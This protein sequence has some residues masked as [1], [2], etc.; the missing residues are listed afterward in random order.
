[1]K[2][3][4]VWFVSLH[5]TSKAKSPR[6]G[7]LYPFWFFSGNPYLIGSCVC[8]VLCL[9]PAAPSWQGNQARN[10]QQWGGSKPRKTPR[11]LAVAGGP[12]EWPAH[13]SLASELP[14][15]GLAWSHQLLCG[16]FAGSSG[17]KTQPG[18]KRDTKW[19]LH[20]ALQP[21]GPIQTPVLTQGRGLKKH[22]AQYPSCARMLGP[23]E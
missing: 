14:G 12:P 16:L 17:D 23:D 11:S 13:R 6:E 18:F 10:G 3:A 9:W 19:F 2:G 1:M 22:N 8:S 21:S 4:F 15:T 7:S 20:R 5:D